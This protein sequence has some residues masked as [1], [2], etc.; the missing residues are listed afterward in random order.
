MTTAYEALQRLRD[1]NARFVAGESR[2]APQSNQE[3]RDALVAGQKP[4]AVILGCSDSRVPV[5]IIFDQ[6]LGDLF[7]I[8]VAGN[9]AQPSQIGSVEFAAASFGTP[10]VVVLGHTQCGAIEATVNVLRTDRSPESPNLGSIVDRILPGISDIVVADDRPDDALKRDATRGNVQS[11]VE[12]LRHG[13]QLIEGL[14]DS[15]DLRIV[16]AEYALETGTVDFFY[17]AD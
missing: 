15:G 6:G 11:T 10:L 17:G 4:F 3:V 2:L 16:G 8:R 13:S 12:T 1:G 7:V 9:I 14:I 5:E